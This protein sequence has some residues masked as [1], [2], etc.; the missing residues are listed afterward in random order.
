[1]RDDVRTIS[2]RSLSW[3]DVDGFARS[4]GFKDRS[5]FVEYCIE[6]T[7]HKDKYTFYYGLVVLLFLTLIMVLLTY[8]S[9]RI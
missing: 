5:P 3:D 7:I 6:K 8:V 4:H 9:L 2:L 1:M